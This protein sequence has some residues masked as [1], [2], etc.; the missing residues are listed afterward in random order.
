MSFHQFCSSDPWFEHIK[1]GRKI[2]EGR[3]Y[4]DKTKD[5]KPG[6]TI[7]FKSVTSGDTFEKKVKNITICDTFEHAL[8]TFPL[9]NILPGIQTIEEGVQV[10]LKYVSLK[11]Q[12]ENRVCII[13]LI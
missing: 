4:W 9:Q 7:E 6:D 8:N 5:I 13:E 2:Y 12:K 11:T 1:S 10:Y 3:R